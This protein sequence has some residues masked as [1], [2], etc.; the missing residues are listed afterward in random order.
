MT[1]CIE[2]YKKIEEVSVMSVSNPVLPISMSFTAMFIVMIL[3]LFTFFVF[4]EYVWF[5]IVALF[6]IDLILG[7]TLIRKINSMPE[8]FQTKVIPKLWNEL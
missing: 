4:E 1:S 8:L 3:G 5:H 6:A 7:T 2:N